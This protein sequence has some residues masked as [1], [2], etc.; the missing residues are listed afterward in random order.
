[1][2]AGGAGFAQQAIDDGL[3]GVGAGEHAAVGFGLEGHAA[4]LEPGDGVTRPE[5]MER[6]DESFAAA[7]IA[8]AEFAG[9][10]A[11][12]GDVAAAAAGDADLG[13]E[14]GAGLEK[15]DFGRG[16]WTADVQPP[17]SFWA[18]VIAA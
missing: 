17:L 9:I 4:G 14:L 5:A 2:D 8:G 1:M 3:R 6:G 11:G 16:G 12:V 18:Q 10:E 7:G 15:E 13:E